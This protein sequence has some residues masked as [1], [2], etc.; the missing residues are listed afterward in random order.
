[1][2]LQKICIFFFCFFFLFLIKEIICICWYILYI[3]FFLF[4]Q[5]FGDSLKPHYRVLDEYLA[6][7]Y[8]WLLIYLHNLMLKHFGNSCWFSVYC[9]REFNQRPHTMRAYHDLGEGDGL[10]DG[11]GD[12]YESDY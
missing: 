10:G 4:W 5:P 3:F 11:D 8:P 1:M 12:G 7:R 9:L 6:R 2:L